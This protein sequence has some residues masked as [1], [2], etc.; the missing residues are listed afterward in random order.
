MTSFD[1]AEVDDVIHGLVRLGTLAY[2]S[3]AKTVEFRELRRRL[4][5]TDGNLSVH[6]KKLE[7]AGYI[8]ME[9]RGAGRGSVTR[10]VL[11]AAGRK[12]FARYVDSMDKLVREVR[13][14]GQVRHTNVGRLE[15][16]S[17]A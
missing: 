17:P 1:P 12:A 15:A 14:A 16:S 8:A 6:L 10:I 4:H 11:T 5:V 9:K 7:T 13:I 3:T 2:L